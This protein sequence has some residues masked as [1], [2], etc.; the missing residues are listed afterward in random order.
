[1][2]YFFRLARRRLLACALVGLLTIVIRLALLPRNPVPEPFVHDEFSYLLAADTFASGRLTNPPH[3]LWQHFE[4]FHIIQQPTYASKYPPA[5]GLILAA[6]QK[7]GHPWIGVLLSMGLMCAAIC[8]MLQGW[9]A[10]GAALF[11][12]LLAMLRIGV[13]GYWMDSY[14]GGAAAGIGGALV[15]GSLPRLMRRPSIPLG[16]V[17]GAGSAILM[18]SRPYEGFILV[19][20]A[21]LGFACMGRWRIRALIPCV[22]AAAIVIGLSIAGMAYYNFAVTGSPAKL[23]YQVH[24]EQYT[25]AAALIWQPL[26]PVPAYRHDV[27]RF[28]WSKW[29]VG[30]YQTAR[31]RPLY[32]FGVKLFLLFLFFVGYW[33][34]LIPLLV[35]PWTW[36]NRRAR[37]ASI[38]GGVFLLA[39]VPERFVLPHY[40]APAA[41]LFFVVLVYGFV[42]LSRWK[43]KGRPRGKVLATVLGL[44]WVIQF[45][46]VTVVNPPQ[47]EN[48]PL[49]R[50]QIL[51]ELQT[52]EGK[53]L[54]FVRYGPTHSFHE[55]WVYNAANIDASR[56]VWSRTMGPAD[57]QSVI[58]YYRDRQVWVLDPDLNP[59]LLTP[60]RAALAS[61]DPAQF[62]K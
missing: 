42:S 11:G 13:T 52:H 15:L 19:A 51:R 57:D 4:S 39:L 23:P 10:P 36:K 25:V 20:A 17:Y 44:A 40:A 41:G 38:L 33:P 47:R 16:L 26:K 32:M 9:L 60:Y 22:A 43:L 3:P 6:G 55:E 12:A 30:I 58:D 62:K 48:F 61:A 34:L 46:G 50:A 21:T 1:M 8:W 37:L 31:D 54:V 29:D 18:N 59:P 49:K 53:H 14:W 24:E 7:L 27:M 2:S 28:M 56:I 45:V 35:V 5:Q